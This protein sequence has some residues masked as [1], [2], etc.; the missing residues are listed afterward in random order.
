VVGG[1]AGGLLLVFIILILLAILLVKV[2]K[3][4]SGIG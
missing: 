2:L 3:P 4:K 1:I